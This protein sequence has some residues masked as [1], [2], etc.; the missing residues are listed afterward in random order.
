[1]INVDRDMHEKET[2]RMLSEA[3]IQRYWMKAFN[4]F[5]VEGCDRTALSWCISQYFLISSNG[6]K[7]MYPILCHTHSNYVESGWKDSGATT[8][9]K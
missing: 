9:P 4:L 3:C 6:M 2:R 1:M 8:V 5:S 7:N